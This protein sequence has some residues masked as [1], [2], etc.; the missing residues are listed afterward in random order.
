[1]RTTNQLRQPHL[2]KQ[3]LEQSSRRFSRNSAKGAF[4]VFT[5]LLIVAATLNL[6]G[7][8]LAAEAGIDAGDLTV[9]SKVHA[10]GV[11]IY[12]CKLDKDGKMSWQ[13]RE[14]LATLVQ[15]GK[16]VGRHFAGPSWEFADGSAVTGR[17]AAQSPGATKDDI[18]LLRLDVIDRRGDGA[19]SKVTAVQRLDTHGGVFSGSCDHKGALHLEPYSAQYVFLAK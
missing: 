14:P 16:T 7:I 1:M 5:S 12:E 13:F 15:D 17:S 8:A 4:P 9:V 2:M 18:A 6:P 3:Y 10:E 11:Q 19:L